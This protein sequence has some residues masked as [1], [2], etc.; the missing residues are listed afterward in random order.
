MRNILWRVGNALHAK[1]FPKQWLGRIGH[2]GPPDASI[3]RVVELGIKKCCRLI[4]WII[5]TYDSFFD[6][7]CVT[8]C[9][10]V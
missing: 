1:A 8:A 2:L 10:Y 9:C 7:G 5:S 4:T 3:I 6:I